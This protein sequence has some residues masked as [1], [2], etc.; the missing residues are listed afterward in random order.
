MTEKSK[1]IHEI[2]LGRIRASIW[3]N[4]TTNGDVWFNA[5][6]SRLYKD[7]ARWKNTTTFGR[8]D[9]PILSKVADMAYGWIWGQGAERSRSSGRSPGLCGQTPDCE[10]KPSADCGHQGL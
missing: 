10:P 1:P 8:D 2:R 7:G 5:T 4:R 6:I 9:L 3:A